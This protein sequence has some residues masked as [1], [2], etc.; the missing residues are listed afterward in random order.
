MREVV[1]VEK[2][3]DQQEDGYASR[4]DEAF[5]MNSGG[6]EQQMANIRTYAEARSDA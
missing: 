4:R 3:S 5:R 1:A 6:W 2:E